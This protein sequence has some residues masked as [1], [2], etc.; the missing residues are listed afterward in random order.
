MSQLYKQFNTSN[1]RFVRFQIKDKKFYI[2]RGQGG[3]IKTKDVFPLE[4]AKG[5]SYDILDLTQE[6]RSN[7]SNTAR[8]DQALNTNKKMRPER[9]EKHIR[10]VI[11]NT[12]KNDKMGKLEF[13]LDKNPDLNKGYSRDASYEKVAEQV[14]D[15]I[16]DNFGYKYFVSAQ[17]SKMYNK[18]W[19]D[20]NPRWWLK[21][22][23]HKSYV[24]REK[25]DDVDDF[26]GNT[27]YKYRLG[28][29]A[30]NKL[31]KGR[32]ASDKNPTW[33]YKRELLGERYKPSKA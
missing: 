4:A 30:R 6:L 5:I 13:V 27:T 7:A 10:D 19:N 8:V 18:K 33:K 31:E 21:H 29:S 2:L 28:A 26:H 25:V 12:Q 16:Y 11:R 1:G 24:V 3:E 9:A 14:V 20:G 32:M 22:L 23:H 15:A 17:F